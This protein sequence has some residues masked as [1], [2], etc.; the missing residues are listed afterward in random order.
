MGPSVIWQLTQKC[1]LACRNCLLVS[2]G[3]R[4]G[5]DEL[6]TFEAY[7]AI[8]QIAALEPKRFTIT[9]GDPLAR[10][11]LLQLID[12]ACRRDLQPAIA[13]SPTHNLTAQNLD[14][15]LHAGMKQMEVSIHGSTPERHDAVHGTP[16][17]F[18]LT[19]EIIGHASV[20]G[21]SVAVDT[22]VTGRTIKDLLSIAEMLDPLGVDAWN[23]YFLVPLDG[24]GSSEAMS[25]AATEDIFGA[26]AAT[27]SKGRLVVRTVEAPQYRRFLMQKGGVKQPHSEGQWSDFSGYIAGDDPMASVDDDIV[28]ITSRGEVRPSVFLPI[29][30]GNLRYRS[31]ASI[32]RSGEIFSAFRK[33]TSLKG[34]CGVCEYREICGG[35]RARAWAITGD[36][37]ASD[38]LCAYEPA[39]M[40]VIA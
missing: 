29:S 34:K 5:V 25:A 6:T 10:R 8:D 31:L 40:E 20:E 1:D 18:T 16:G 11:D 24:F 27:A 12:Y 26:L 28:F 38:P 32:V 35:S 39:A 4:R 30:G 33:R 7:K 17:A 36:L 3:S 23:L 13:L 14:A 15:L 2:E 37:F 21:V 19:M 22:L 9:G